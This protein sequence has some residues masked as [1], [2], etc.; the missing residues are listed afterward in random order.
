MLAHPTHISPG[1][2]LEV[3]TVHYLCLLQF[4]RHGA[5]TGLELTMQE[6]ITLNLVSS[7]LHFLIPGVGRYTWLM[8][9]TV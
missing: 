2:T 1:D 6:R 3:T 8:L 9:R 7:C 4:L 5:K